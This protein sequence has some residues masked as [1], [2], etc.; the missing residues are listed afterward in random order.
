[1]GFH[2]HRHLF[3]YHRHTPFSMTMA[4]KSQ[5]F[6]A[7]AWAR[8]SVTERKLKDLVCDGLL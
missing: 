3:L 6:P 8:S 5:I 2:R 1:L 4:G 7:D